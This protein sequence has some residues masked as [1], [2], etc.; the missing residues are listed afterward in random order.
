MEVYL[1]LLFVEHKVLVFIFGVPQSV[2][3]VKTVNSHKALRLLEQKKLPS[4]NTLTTATIS[5]KITQK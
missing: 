2:Q 3:K 5:I 1:N 4:H